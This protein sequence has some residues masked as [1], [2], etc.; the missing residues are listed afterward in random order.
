MIVL[1]GSVPMAFGGTV[2]PADVNKNLSAAISAILA[3][4]LYV[5]KLRFFL[6]FYDTKP[7]YITAFNYH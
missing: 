7:S 3:T 5:P 1:K 4:K 2:Q 6:R